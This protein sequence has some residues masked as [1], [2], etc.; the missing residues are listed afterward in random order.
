[1]EISKTFPGLDSMHAE[2]HM[3]LIVV[4]IREGSFIYLFIGGTGA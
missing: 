3:V 1:M 2:F 4:V